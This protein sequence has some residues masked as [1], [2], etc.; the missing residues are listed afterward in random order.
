MQCLEGQTCPGPILNTSMCSPQENAANVSLCP[1]PGQI[2]PCP[3][4]SYCHLRGGPAECPQGS[5]CR[6][7]SENPMR[8]PLLADCPAGSVDNLINFTLELVIVVVALFI[9]VGLRLLERSERLRQ[10]R[11]KYSAPTP[12][13]EERLSTIRQKSWNQLGKAAEQ[14]SWSLLTDP[15][16]PKPG[17]QPWAEAR[18]DAS[19][20]RWLVG[21]STDDLAYGSDSGTPRT[22]GTP[23]SPISP[24]RRKLVPGG[25]GGAYTAVP[26]SADGFDM[27]TR[28]SAPISITFEN[29]GLTLKSNPDK[30]IIRGIT[31]TFSPRAVTAIMGPSGTGKTSLL[32]VILDRAYYG[33]GACPLPTIM[34]PIPSLDTCRRF[35]PWC[36]AHANRNAHSP[37][38]RNL[39]FPMLVRG[40]VLINGVEGKLRSIRHDVGFVPQDD[41]MH[42]ALTVREVLVYQAELRLPPSWKRRHILAIVR[43]TIV[44]L[45][46]EEIA[47]T[48]VGDIQTRG[49]SGGQRKRVNIGMELV[50][51]T[52]NPPCLCP[53][54]MTG[55]A[56]IG[57]RRFGVCHVHVGCTGVL[58]WVSSPRHMLRGASLVV[59]NQV[60]DPR[61]LVLDE[62]TSGLDS[63][64]GLRVVEALQ[65]AAHVKGLTVV[66]VLHQPRFEIF[67]CFDRLL[68]LGPGGTTCYEGKT[69]TAVRHFTKLGYKLPSLM[70]PADFLMDVSA[71]PCTV[72]SR[73]GGR[74]GGPNLGA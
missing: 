58:V 17:T 74:L 24:V 35:R 4:G 61:V 11:V 50:R 10:R 39:A 29:L 15:P 7:G 14:T 38:C 27:P 62:P 60:A 18:Q 33:N 42:A 69:Q 64:S 1:G 6:S 68:L 47:D 45:E 43:D 34:R 3:A 65:K 31:G 63:T 66:T 13:E 56:T 59:G 40:R 8:C 71:A 12:V 32:N 9:L 51:I 70:N 19:G 21:T 5:Y 30:T 72:L 36:W 41:V 25:A 54:A 46:L 53:C 57:L 37:C 67:N 2:I 20:V 73:R 28:N 52:C 22:P 16:T 23:E 55:R 49:I 48:K 26:Q 44:M